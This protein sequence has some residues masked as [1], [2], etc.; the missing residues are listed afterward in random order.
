[1]YEVHICV[2]L[3]ICICICVWISLH[4]GDSMMSRSL[5][6]MYIYIIYVYSSVFR[7]YLYIYRKRQ[8]PFVCCK[9]KTEMENGSLFSPGRLMINSNRRLLFQQTFPHMKIVHMFNVCAHWA[10]NS[11]LPSLARKF[12]GSRANARCHSPNRY[13]PIPGTWPGRN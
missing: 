12:W 13:G 2:C 8:L 4:R 6:C 1:M 3:C 7:I 9:R 11:P 5:L 10:E